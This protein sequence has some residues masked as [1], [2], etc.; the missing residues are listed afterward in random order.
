[1]VFDT[2]GGLMFEPALKSLRHRG[3]LLEITS[4]GDRRVGFDLLDFY[5]NESQLFGID[6]RARDAVASSILLEASRRSSSG[7]PSAHPQS[8]G[9]LH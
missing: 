8:T 6:T 4:A 1:V 7:E 5:H 2:V 3:R 9:R